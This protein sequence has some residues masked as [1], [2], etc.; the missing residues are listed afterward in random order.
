MTTDVSNPPIDLAATEHVAVPDRCGTATLDIVVPVHNEAVD[1]EPCVRRL[2]G[3]LRDE[4]PV[5]RRITIVDN[6]ST[7]GTWQ[8]A[9]RLASE[10]LGARDPARREGPR[11]GAARGVG[12]TATRPC[13]P[14]WT[15]TSRPTSPRFTRSSHRCCRATAT[16]RSGPG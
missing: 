14:T 4:L 3:Y 1:L 11:S 12:R 16:W 5:E 6:A 8:I 7:D 10:L 9:E 13:S 15:S 2:H